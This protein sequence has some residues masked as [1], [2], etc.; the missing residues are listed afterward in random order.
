MKIMTIFQKK[1]SVIRPFTQRPF[2]QITLRL[3]VNFSLKAFCQINF[4]SNY[5]LITL[6]FGQM[7]FYVDSVDSVK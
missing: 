6:F 3:N 2:G 5:L 1:L 7:T 4:R